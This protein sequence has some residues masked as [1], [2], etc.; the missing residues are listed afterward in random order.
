[1]TTL[2]IRVLFASVFALVALGGALALEAMDHDCPVWL[3]SVVSG[4]VGYIFGQVHE[5][6][7]SSLTGG[8]NNTPGG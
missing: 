7:A 8:R 6:G 4:A 2:M 5:N 3:V 1:M